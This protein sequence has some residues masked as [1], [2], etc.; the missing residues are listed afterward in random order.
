MQLRSLQA[1]S[2]LLDVAKD[3]FDDDVLHEHVDIEGESDDGVLIAKLRV[4]EKLH[5]GF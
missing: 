1:M 2:R 3:G 5:V 4:A